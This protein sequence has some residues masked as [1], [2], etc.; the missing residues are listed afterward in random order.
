MF[1]AVLLMGG[2][3]VR[4][5]SQ[6]PKQYHPLSGKP[7]YRVTLDLFIKSALFEE[8]ILSCDPDWIEKV[9][10]EVAGLPG[11]RCVAGG[12][13]RQ[14]SSY[15]GLKGFGKRPEVVLIH[16]A[17]R[18]FVSIDILRR[19]C[20]LA[21][22]HRA[23][24]TCIPTADTLVHSLDGKQI[25]SIPARSEY[26]RGQT[27]QSFS[28]PLILE[29]HERARRK[30]ASD[31]CRLVLDLGQP[32]W[33]TEGSE[34][35][36][37]ITSELDLFIAEQL[38]RLNRSEV[39][40]GASLAKKTFAVV[41]GSGGIGRAICAQLEAAGARAI[42]LSRTSETPLD[43]KDPLSIDAAFER[44]GPIDGL[45]NCAGF[46]L[47]KPFEMLTLTEIESML[48]VNLSGLLVCCQ[49]AKI[50][51]GGHIVNIASSSFAKGRKDTA[52]Y[53]CTKAAVVNFT[54]ALAEE[55]PDLRIHAVIPQRTR[56]PM[57]LENFPNEEM[58][59]LL[60]PEEVA[61]K[62]IDVLKDPDSTGMLVEVR[63]NYFLPGI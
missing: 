53:S 12:A 2:K 48:Q 45:I 40:S 9:K 11:V 26:L 24:D 63:K 25:S 46:L 1:G 37:K 33:I 14:E 22:K 8:I 5:G 4:F 59:S 49:K 43:L 56:T 36:L 29:A 17:V 41:G 10:D 57:R 62:V 50:K 6:M 34:S 47:N 21:L 19:N 55:R 7:I 28:Y 44:L 32:V 23:V 58:S 35:N 61:H 27:P 39:R 13:T 16:D 60:E 51:E 38:F 3:G 30:D 42:S 15:C 18:P 20:E 52:V 31:D 54:Q